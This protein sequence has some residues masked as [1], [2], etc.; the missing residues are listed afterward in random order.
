MTAVLELEQVEQLVKLFSDCSYA[1]GTNANPKVLFLDASIQMHKIMKGKL[2]EA[3]TGMKISNPLVW[4]E[5]SHL[6]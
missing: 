5:A 6:T 4:R 3:Y 1:G 2:Q